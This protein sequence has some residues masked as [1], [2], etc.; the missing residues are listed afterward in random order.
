MKTLFKSL[1]LFLLMLLFSTVAVFAQQRNLNQKNQPSLEEHL[2]QLKKELALSDEQLA[3]VKP[4][5]EANREKN[6]ASRDKMRQELKADRQNRRAMMKEMRVATASN[7][8]HLNASLQEIL[9]KEQ[10]EK[11]QEIQ[12][13]KRAEMMK[14]NQNQPNRQN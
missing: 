3:L 7:Q 9:T 14:K 12:K 4:L 10:F 2:A 5:I 1:L 6:M 8:Q 11:L 13:N